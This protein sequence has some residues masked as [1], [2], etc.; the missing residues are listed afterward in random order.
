MAPKIRN[1]LPLVVAL[2]LGVLLA[3]FLP[4]SALAA[5]GDLDPSFGSGGVV[6]GP[7]GFAYGVSLQR[8][9]KIVVAGSPSGASSFQVVRY[10]TDGTMDSSFGVGGVATTDF[11]LC[12]T[13]AQDV[14][15]QQDGRVLAVGA[16]GYF[17]EDLSF[18]FA[19]YMQ[20]G[21]PDLTFGSSGKVLIQLQS[22]ATSAAIQSDGKIVAAGLYGDV[23]RLLPD[24]TLDPTFG[25]GGEVVLNISGG[26]AVAI[27]GDGKIVVAGYSGQLPQT[28]G[29]VARLNPDGT[30]D[31][32]FG[33]G[34][35]LY[36]AGGALLSVALQGDG[37]IVVTG[38]VGTHD[39][40][41]VLARMNADGTLD[42]SFA[43][44]GFI[45]TALSPNDD[46]AT[47]VLIQGDGKIVAT[48]FAHPGA[49]VFALVRYKTTGRLDKT[50]GTG[51]QVLIPTGQGQ[52][53]VLQRDRK[54]VVCGVG[55]GGIE[56]ARYLGS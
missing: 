45:V 27:Q 33:T 37:K 15:V 4:G 30:P 56:L 53:G 5:P 7:L 42:S 48:G 40:D 1:H 32:S 18:A 25:S 41:F 28:V 10:Q 13:F 12:C 31:A 26:N 8:D 9:G 24:G 38:Y 34:G 3:A 54:I 36:L 17:G 29:V 11:G 50:F 19:R 49:Y 44:R 47:A 20:D 39:K 35:Y 14:L 51:G 46:V 2:L 22:F 55:G 43:R 52:D 21:E 6:Q 23:V 16:A